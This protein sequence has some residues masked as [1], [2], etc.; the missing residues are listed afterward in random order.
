[1][2]T[3]VS[4]QRAIFNPEQAVAFDAVLE[5]VTS[6][7]GHIFFIYAAG[8]CEKTF[9]YNTIAAEVRRKE[10]VALYVASSGITTLLLDRERTS[11]SRFKIPILIY[12]DSVARLKCNSCMFPVIQ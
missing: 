8:S 11:H 4:K 12:E 3:L 5:S 1:M 9:L 2:V 6:N 10:Q 7:Q